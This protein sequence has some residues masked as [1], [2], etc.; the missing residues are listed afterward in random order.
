MDENQREARRGEI[1]RQHMSKAAEEKTWTIPAHEGRGPVTLKVEIP[2][3]RITDSEGRHIII[4][5]KQLE[6]VG[7]RISDVADWLQHG[8]QDWVEQND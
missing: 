5:P 1:D 6:I 7:S 8:D 3:A 2:A 4:S